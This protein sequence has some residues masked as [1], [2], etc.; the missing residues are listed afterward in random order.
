MHT[1][2]WDGSSWVTAT[3]TIHGNVIVDGSL[4]AESLIA[5]DAFL[6]TLGVNNIYDNAA[7]SSGNPVANYKMRISLVNGSIHIR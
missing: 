5:D 1:A 3:Q 4:R 6:Q 7:I 2:Q